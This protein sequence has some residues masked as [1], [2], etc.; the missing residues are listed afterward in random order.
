MATSTRSQTDKKDTPFTDQT[1]SAAHEAIDRLSAR[2]GRTEE[3]LRSAASQG[4]DQWT[5]R[6][7]QV[8]EQ[9]E[10]SVSGARDY[11]REN[12]LAAAGI[13]FAAGVV[14]ASLLRR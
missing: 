14:V 9:V 2:V 1:V 7:E 4:R 8:R 12:P 6:Q 10:G 3:Q 5:E 13:A 11:A